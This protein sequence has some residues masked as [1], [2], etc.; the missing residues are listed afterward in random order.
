MEEG[1]LMVKDIRKFNG[2]LLDKW[3]WHLL[4]KEQGKWKDIIISKYGSESN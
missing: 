1:G 3:K 2:A 4:R